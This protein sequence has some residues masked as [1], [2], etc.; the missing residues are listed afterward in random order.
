MGLLVCLSAT[1]GKHGWT[2]FHEI[3]KIGRGY[4]PRNNRYFFIFFIFFFGGGEGYLYLRRFCYLICQ[5][6]GNSKWADSQEIL[7]KC[8]S[9]YKDQSGKMKGITCN[10]MDPG[11]P[12]FIYFFRKS[13]H[14]LNITGETENGF[15]YVMDPCLL[16]ILWKRANRFL[17]NDHNMAGTTEEIISWT[18]S[19][20]T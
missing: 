4:N 18:A 10:P 8:R 2:E 12:L 16:A 14:V 17:W 13:E 11:I 7:R 1:L 19:L 20:L 3:I 9:W 6:Y 5:H 15:F